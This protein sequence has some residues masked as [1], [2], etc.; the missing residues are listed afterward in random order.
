M[1]IDTAVNLFSRV[2]LSSSHVSKVSNV[3]NKKQITFFRDTGITQTNRKEKYQN[4]AINSSIA[5]YEEV[6]RGIANL[7]C[8][9]IARTTVSRSGQLFIDHVTG[10]TASH[11]LNITQYLGYDALSTLSVSS[12]YI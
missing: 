9:T 2:Q 4:I 3:S 7:T 12:R 11:I 1:T 5:V 8:S 10:N 6:F